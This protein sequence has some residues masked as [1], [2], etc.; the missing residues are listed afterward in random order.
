[1][2]L[3]EIIEPRSRPKFDWFI[4]IDGDGEHIGTDKAEI[5]PTFDYLKKVALTAFKFSSPYLAIIFIA[6]ILDV[7]FR[8]PIF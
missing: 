4:P 1:M 6:L 8:F 5:P 7:L 3:S 2:E